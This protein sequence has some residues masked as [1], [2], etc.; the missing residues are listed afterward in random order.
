M[1]LVPIESGEFATRTDHDFNLHLSINM[2]E[3]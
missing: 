1:S 3:V 2:R